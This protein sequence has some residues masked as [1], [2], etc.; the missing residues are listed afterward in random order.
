M[1]EV[2][3]DKNGAKPQRWEIQ[4]SLDMG[5]NPAHEPGGYEE[6]HKESLIEGALGKVL[7]WYFSCMNS[8][9]SEHCQ[10]IAQESQRFLSSKGSLVLGGI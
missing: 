4:V 7:S 8:F 9:F 5:S 1:G 2:D 3:L 6:T 10:G